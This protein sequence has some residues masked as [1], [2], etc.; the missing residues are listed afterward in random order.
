MRAARN[1]LA[2]QQPLLFVENRAKRHRSRA[3]LLDELAAF[4]QFRTRTEVTSLG[5]GEDAVPVFVNEF[6]TSKQRAASSLHEI[7]YRACFKP[8]LPRFFI[9]RLTAANDMVYDPFLG[10]GTTM[11]E[12]A[13]LGRRV[14]GCDI[15]P[16]SSILTAPRL[17]PP[18]V[19]DVR[20]RLADLDWNYE[21][22]I[23]EEL[24]TF[25]HPDTLREICGLRSHLL[26]RDA[27]HTASEVD[28]WIR[29]VATNRLTGH[30]A[31][32][33]SVYTLPP[34]QALT[35]KRQQKINEIRKQVPP[36]R[37][38][39]DL[40]IRKTESLLQTVSEF[41]R[42][43]LSEAASN[44]VLLARSSDR[45]PEIKDNSVD[46][47]VTSPPFLDVVD[48][49][50]DNWL[51][52]WFNGIEEN[53]IDI[54][55]FRKPSE[56]VRAMERVFVELRRVLRRGAYIAF[57]VGEVRRGKLRMEELVVPAAKAAKFIPV[58]VL[59][60]S[61]VFTKTSNCWG[62]TNQIAG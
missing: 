35:P 61:Q 25:Y 37:R 56:W 46:L 26:L 39:P 34:N 53:N 33:F 55:T 17:H 28:D 4:R 24:L 20:A 12:A 49:A 5:E 8:Q 31:G 27:D 15:N 59:I 43:R 14:A 19:R 42:S 11:I 44:A 2:E 30:S 58:L 1:I 40:I 45:T 10:R 50:A 23:N 16:L 29:M 6:W 32:F 22:E 54:W 3:S 41:D 57:E 62:V 9:E 48:Y 13:L 21:D 38:V 36:R 47:I 7:S 60:N 18:T 52:C 51:R